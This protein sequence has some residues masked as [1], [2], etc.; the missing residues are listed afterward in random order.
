MTQTSS[1]MPALSDNVRKAMQIL[2]TPRR[3]PRRDP[4]E[5]TAA[6]RREEAKRKKK[7]R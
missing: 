6:D 7:R 5:G 2:A 1:S 4:A 3:K